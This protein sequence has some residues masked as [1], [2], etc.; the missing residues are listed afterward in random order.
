[1]RRIIILVTTVILIVSCGAPGDIIGPLYKESLYESLTP[2]SYV[3]SFG[4]YLTETKAILIV[5]GD[6]NRESAT[7]TLK[8]Y[9]MDPLT[10]EFGTEPTAT[11]TGT[12]RHERIQREYMSRDWTVAYHIDVIAFNDATEDAPYTPEELSG[13]FLIMPD[14]YTCID[15]SDSPSSHWYFPQRGTTIRLYDRSYGT[16]KSTLTD[17]GDWERM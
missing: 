2:G 9:E 12:M 5:D 17:F 16:E 15:H 13:R 6:H 3:A 1:M 14:A 10:E 8:L 4:G 7:V 11:Y